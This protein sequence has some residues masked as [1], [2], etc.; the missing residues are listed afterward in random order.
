MSLPSVLSTRPDRSCG[1]G[2]PHAA[3][4]KGLK[5]RV[6]EQPFDVLTPAF[7]APRAVRHAGGIAGAALGTHARIEA[8]LGLNTAIKKL[9]TAFGDSVV[10]PRFIETIPQAR[11]PLHCAGAPAGEKQPGRLPAALQAISGGAPDRIAEP[12]SVRNHVETGGASKL[13]NENTL[14]SETA[15]LAGAKDGQID[16]MIGR[17]AHLCRLARCTKRVG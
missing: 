4:K 5:V 11:L 17:V 2:T 9:R 7:K 15:R 3:R 8:E 10:N 14:P 13:P 16:S 1:T 12:A 6:Q